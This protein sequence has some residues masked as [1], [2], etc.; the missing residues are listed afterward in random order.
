[1]NKVIHSALIGE[2]ITHGTIGDKCMATPNVTHPP[3]PVPATTPQEG[4]YGIRH[5]SPSAAEFVFV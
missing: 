5:S 2:R 1:L 3:I 4:S